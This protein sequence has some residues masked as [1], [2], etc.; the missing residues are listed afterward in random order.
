[1]VIAITTILIY[2][3]NYNTNLTG[4]SFLFLLVFVLV[5]GL[6]FTMTMIRFWRTPKRAITAKPDEIVSPADGN[7]IYIKKVPQGQ[8]PITFK[9]KV[10]ATLNELSKTELLNEPAW[11]IGINMTPFDVHKNC[12][13]IDGQVILNR[14]FDG[15]FLSLKN[16]MAILENERNTYVI[17]NNK[18][19]VGVVQIA[20]RLVRRIDSYVQ[21]GQDLQKGDWLG[22]IRFGSQVDVII[23]LQCEIAIKVKQQLYAGKTVIAVSCNE[24]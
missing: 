8:I 16:S 23:P 7:V 22:M 24:N 5:V 13:P 19:M 11:L 4:S 1:M 10:R 2:S 15:Q 6:A 12:S 21:V 9:N 17:Q 14:H 3:I 18:L 20:S